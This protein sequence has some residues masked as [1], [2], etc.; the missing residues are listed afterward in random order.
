MAASIEKR[1]ARHNDIA[2]ALL[3]LCGEGF[4]K[5]QLKA[6]IV[7]ERKLTKSDSNKNAVSLIREGVSFMV[8][9]WSLREDAQSR[10]LRAE[11]SPSFPRLLFPDLELADIL[12]HPDFFTR[13]ILEAKRES[14]RLQ[15][16]ANP[17]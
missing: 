3:S 15:T 14:E 8:G 4:T 1:L 5:S 13:L 7:L 16:K 10:Q 6:Y 2:D 17:N 12:A 11:R 9:D